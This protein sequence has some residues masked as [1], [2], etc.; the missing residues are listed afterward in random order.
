MVRRASDVRRNDREHVARDSRRIAA[1][2]ELPRFV[3][4]RLAALD[5]AAAEVEQADPDEHAREQRALSERARHRR[6]SARRARRRDP[7]RRS[8]RRTRS[9]PPTSTRG[10]AASEARRRSDAPRR[11]AGARRR[12]SPVSPPSIASAQCAD[13][14][15][16]RCPDAS[17]SA[18]A[19]APV[20]ARLSAGPVHTYSSSSDA[21][22]AR[23]QPVVA[24]LGRD[25]QRAL[26]LRARIARAPDRLQAARLRDEHPR[27]ELPIARARAPRRSP[28]RSAR[29]PRRTHRAN[30]APARSSLDRRDARRIVRRARIGQRAPPELERAGIV[31]EPLANPRRA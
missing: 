6:S 23:E 30:S 14:A 10:T 2:R 17:A 1:A 20:L 29:A 3:D 18:M 7:N 5:V 13:H 25:R 21:M 4:A 11:D 28:R 26:D 8:R 31:A 9:R 24:E 16:L 22:H 12:T 19:C 27:L 15:T